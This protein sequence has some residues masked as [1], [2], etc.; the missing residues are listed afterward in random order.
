MWL[1][2]RPGFG[3]PQGTSNRPYRKSAKRSV[4]RK[5]R[6][7]EE[8]IA[9]LLWTEMMALALALMLAG[10][11]TALQPDFSTRRGVLAA[12]AASLASSCGPANAASSS[13]L[14]VA[15]M[16]RDRHVMFGV[17]PPHIE[18]VLTYDELLAAAAAGK[19]ATVQTAVQHDTV[20]ATTP[21]GSRWACHVKDEDVP[22]LVADAMRDDSSVPFEVL[23]I[24]PVKQKVRE[25][26]FNYVTLFGALY[27]AG[28]LDM[29]YAPSP[30]QSS[31]PYAPHGLKPYDPHAHVHVH[32]P[33]PQ[34]STRRISWTPTLC[35][36]RTQP[37]AVHPPLL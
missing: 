36:T 22:G 8:G 18:G 30:P 28:Q 21:H 5:R 17:F 6:P 37:P 16:D 27:V 10:G 7:K 3:A 2:G 31:T 12:A 26:W 14:N 1:S 35:S 15:T 13:G 19:V 20:I 9:T 34:P 33:K 32:G 24:D 25:V 11:A 29:L 4:P 23:P